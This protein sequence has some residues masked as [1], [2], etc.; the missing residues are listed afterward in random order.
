MSEV[1][2]EKL[3]S[4]IKT[5]LD[6]LVQ[7]FKDAGLDKKPGDN[8]T[9]GEKKQLLDHLS[10]AHGNSGEVAPQ[11]MTL[12]RKTTSTLSVGKSK[13]V[14]VEVRKKRTFVQRSPEE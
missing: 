14:K 1:S 10:K 11:K 4:D 5:P 2:I 8:V 12:K 7:Q 9:E 3:A 13:N 6:R